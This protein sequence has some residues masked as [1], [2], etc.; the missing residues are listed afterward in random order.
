MSGKRGPSRS[1]LGPVSAF[2]PE[3]LMWSVMAIKSPGANW[4]LMPPAA[5]ISSIASSVALFSDSS[6]IAVVPVSENSTP[7]LI[8]P[9]AA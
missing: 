3:R 8:S 5:L 4:V 9:P 2:H 6:M 7:T 1:S